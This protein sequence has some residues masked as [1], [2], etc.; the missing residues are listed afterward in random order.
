MGSE[1]T[2]LGVIASVIGGLAAILVA[3]I[4][5]PDPGQDEDGAGAGDEL[6]VS[7]EIWQRFER[8]ERKVDHLTALVETKKAEVSALEKMLRSAM[9]IVRRQQR[10]LRA[11]GERPEEVPLELIPYSI[12]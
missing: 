6:K 5:R 4:S 2:V 11:H 10:R 8:L 7:P 12:D 3:R 9:R 1:G